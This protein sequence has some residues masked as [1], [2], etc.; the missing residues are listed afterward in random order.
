[1]TTPV[2]SYSASATMRPM[3]LDDLA[4]AQALVLRSVDG[5]LSAHYPTSELAVLRRIA[6]IEPAVVAQGGMLVIEVSGVPAAV[7]GWSRSCN[8]PITDAHVSLK[9][10]TTAQMRSLF[11]KPDFAGRGFGRRILATA[12]R[13]AVV[14][15]FRG[16]VLLATAA[17]APVYRRA[18]W[19]DAGWIAVPGGAQLLRMVKKFPACDLRGHAA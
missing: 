13:N 5:L 6:P 18:G 4:A 15:G 7:G 14:H 19:L 8:A 1:M 10:G 12:E 9:P 17:G 16:G 11:V 2:P 3:K